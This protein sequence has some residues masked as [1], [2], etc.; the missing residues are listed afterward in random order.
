VGAA[1]ALG[2]SLKDG[3]EHTLGIGVQ[4]GVP[5]PQNRPSFACQKSVA[6]NVTRAIRMMA[7]VQLD[8]EPRLAAGEIGD[9]GAD[10]QLPGELRASWEADVSLFCA[11]AHSPACG[12]A[13]RRKQ[14]PPQ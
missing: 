6:S 7:T 10:P 11:S 12:L 13:V 1:E 14:P 3:V 2:G 5:H 8:D 4:L 9:I